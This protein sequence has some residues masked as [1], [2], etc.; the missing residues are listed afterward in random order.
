MDQVQSRRAASSTLRY[1]MD[2]A[3]EAK[4]FQVSAPDVTCSL[5]F[6]ANA[7]A[8]LSTQ[9]AQFDLPPTDLAKLDGPAT[10]DGDSLQVSV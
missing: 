2:G 3:G 7:K 6:S 9:Y 1:S 4:N 8:L 5:S 10:I